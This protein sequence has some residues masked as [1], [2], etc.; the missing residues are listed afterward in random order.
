MSDLNA[1][2][3]RIEGME[4]QQEPASIKGTVPLAEIFGYS[5]AI[6]SLSQGRAGFSMQPSNYVPVPEEVARKL[7]F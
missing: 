6:R 5:T 4:T 7:S 2:R 1:R 3:G